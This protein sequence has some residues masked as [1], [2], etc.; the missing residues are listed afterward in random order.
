MA[1]NIDPSTRPFDRLAAVRSVL[2][3]F[4]MEGLDPDLETAVLLER[5]TEGAISL[6]EFGMAI[7]RHAANLAAQEP[8]EGAA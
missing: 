4:R 3:S 7:E 8:T 1:V 5:Y 6:E 2:A